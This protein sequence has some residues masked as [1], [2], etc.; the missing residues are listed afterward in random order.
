MPVSGL[1][2]TSVA[3]VGKFPGRR[4]CEVGLGVLCSGDFETPLPGE[5]TGDFE[6][7]SFPGEPTGDCAG[8]DFLLPMAGK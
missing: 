3:S 2:Y 4:F 8:G 1:G 7:R 5:A 6:A